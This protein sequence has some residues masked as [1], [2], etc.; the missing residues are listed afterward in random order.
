MP[1][2]SWPIALGNAF[3]I[4]TR[5]EPRSSTL[6]TSIP[7]SLRFSRV[8]FRGIIEDIFE[9]VVYQEDQATTLMTFYNTTLLNGSARFTRPHPRSGSSV[10]MRF[11]EKPRLQ[12]ISGGVNPLWRTQL[13]LEALP[14]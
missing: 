9:P 5:V 1:I 11:V 2:A 10:Q 4:E 14:S 6:R 7:G 8:R 3:H 12:V 13:H